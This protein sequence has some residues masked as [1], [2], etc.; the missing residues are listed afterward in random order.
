MK[1]K[2]WMFTITVAGVLIA[3]GNAN[4]QGNLSVNDAAAK[5]IA[6]MQTAMDLA[7]RAKKAVEEASN[8][9]Q[10]AIEIAEAKQAA[11]Q[12][13]IAN[14]AQETVRL[15]KDAENKA[16]WA[17]I[18]HNR[19]IAARAALM[20]AALD[21]SIAKKV[22]AE[23]SK[24]LEEARIQL[25]SHQNVANQ[26]V[27]FKAEAEKLIQHVIA[28]ENLAALSYNREQSESITALHASPMPAHSQPLVAQA[29][30]SPAKKLKQTSVS[31]PAVTM[32]AKTDKTKV[33]SQS[34][35]KSASK[36]TQQASTQRKNTPK[37][38]LASLSKP[39]SANVIRGHNL[40]KK[41]QVCHTFK[42]N[43]K[44][45]FGPSLFGIVGQ[46]AGKSEGYRYSNTLAEASFNWNEAALNN[47][48][49]NSKSA[50]KQLTGNSKASTK[51]PSQRACGQ[52]A[53]DIVAY[54][55]SLKAQPSQLARADSK[56]GNI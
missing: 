40:S 17:I 38:T 11:V 15:K 48:I 24:A 19:V 29:K 2:T 4:D 44:A 10:L 43:Q 56:S 23:K 25:A 55:A 9:K 53:K 36:T 37:L 42:E 45:K 49:C 8:N 41:C 52:D 32:M 51:M 18:T 7:V 28:A 35:Q 50:I 3:C 20:Q 34:H 5:K 13:I 6:E 46:K 39:Q 22:V 47:W 16:R 26:A 14:A 1:L 30:V 12:A 54:L 31:K 33:K 21:Q 27:Q